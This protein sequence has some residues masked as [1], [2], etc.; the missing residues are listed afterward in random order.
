MSTRAF[1]LARGARKVALLGHVLASV[2]WFGMA[3][4]VAAAGITA[5]AT[6]DATLPPVLYRVMAD[7]VWL[8]VPMGLVAAATGVVLGV[9]T[10]WG[11]V[12]HGWVVAKIV[13]TTAVLVTDPIVVS[14]AANRA[15]SSGDAPRPL[16]G[17]TIAH[18]VMLTVATALSVFK[19]GGRTPFARRSFVA[20]RGE[21]RA[22][23][24]H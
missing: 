5:A 3:I 14:R 24:G 18:C 4:V 17:S 8:T 23:V 11:L 22:A 6:G 20:Q 7:A 16:Y 2:G 19:P 1:R 12:K 15:L 13:I 10:T 21:Q 9:G